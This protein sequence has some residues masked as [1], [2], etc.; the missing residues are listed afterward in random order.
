M[1]EFCFKNNKYYDALLFSLL[2]SDWNKIKHYY[3]KTFK[4]GS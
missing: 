4:Y 2:K 3:Y 1:R